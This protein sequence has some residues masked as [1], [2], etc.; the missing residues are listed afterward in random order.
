MDFVF[1][2]MLFAKNLVFKK[3]TINTDYT[4]E[5]NSTVLIKFEGIAWLLV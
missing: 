4:R 5:P 3:L 2:L 1:F